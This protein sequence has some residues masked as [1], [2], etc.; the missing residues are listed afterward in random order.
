MNYEV[1]A[2]PPSEEPI[3]NVDNI[4]TDDGIYDEC[5]IVHGRG[6]SRRSKNNKNNAIQF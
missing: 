3:T 5:E 6:P 2:A 1:K 4:G